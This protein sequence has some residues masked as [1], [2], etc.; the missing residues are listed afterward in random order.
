MHLITVLTWVGSSR[1]EHAALHVTPNNSRRRVLKET[2]DGPGQNIRHSKDCFRPH[3]VS[4]AED[5]LKRIA[6]HVYLLP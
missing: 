4:L 3:N 1:A 5:M 6:K 2:G